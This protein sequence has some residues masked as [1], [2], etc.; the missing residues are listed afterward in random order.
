[1]RPL[2]DDSVFQKQKG[3]VERFDGKDYIVYS[4]EKT[5]GRNCTG[6]TI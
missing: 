6:S 4:H 5:T 3:V 1:M 2:A